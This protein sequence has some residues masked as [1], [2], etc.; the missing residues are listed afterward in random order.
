MQLLSLCYWSH[1]FPVTIC[2]INSF[3]SFHCTIHSSTLEYF[4]Q[5]LLERSFIWPDIMKISLFLG[6]LHAFVFKAFCY[7]SMLYLSSLGT[8]QHWYID[9]CLQSSHDKS[10]SCPY[11]TFWNMPLGCLLCTLQKFL[12][13]LI[14]FHKIICLIWCRHKNLDQI[15]AP[16]YLITNISVLFLS[17]CL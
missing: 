1:K 13:S 14:I 16:D 9:P 15:W 12:S 2:K 8:I 4:F 17:L 5:T 11:I 3:L 10:F 6:L 7:L